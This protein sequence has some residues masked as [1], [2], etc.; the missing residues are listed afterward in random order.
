MNYLLPTFKAVSVTFAISA[1]ITG[2]QGILS[3]V[4][5][6]KF[7][8]LPLPPVCDD[9]DKAHGTIR[10]S[11]LQSERKLTESY[12]ALMSV[13]QLGTGII[14]LTFAYQSKWSEVA[15]IL[16]I[17]GVLVA[18]T[19]GIYLVRSGAKEQGR[20]HALPGALISALSGVVVYLNA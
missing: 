14:L 4:S 18:G 15:T 17:I 5:F 7:F 13:R 8:G 12:V 6:S 3:P 2:L 20:F 1:V 9:N 10:M 11:K 19:D 16:A